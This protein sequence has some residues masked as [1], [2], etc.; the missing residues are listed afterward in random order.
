MIKTFQG[1]SEKAKEAIKIWGAAN[2]LKAYKMNT[3]DGEGASMIS[4]EF[5]N[6]DRINGNMLI[7]AGREIVEK[8]DA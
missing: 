7:N 5:S 2:C 4:Y 8:N 6:G 3:E 1:Y